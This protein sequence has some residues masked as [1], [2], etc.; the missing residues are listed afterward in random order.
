MRADTESLSCLWVIH[1]WSVM[2]LR[3]HQLP[4]IPDDADSYQ[5][6]LAGAVVGLL[7]AR[8]GGVSVHTIE[9]LDYGTSELEYL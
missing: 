4:Q 7:G 1:Y 3:D 2:D 9:I 5:A 8:S 6:D